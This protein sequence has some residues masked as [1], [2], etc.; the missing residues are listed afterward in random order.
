M[1]V[2]KRRVIFYFILLSSTAWVYLATYYLFTERGSEPDV[3]VNDD[4]L[5]LDNLQ[6]PVDNSKESNPLVLAVYDKTPDRN[7]NKPGEWG[8]GVSLNFLEKKQEEAGYALH[9]FN[10]V[11]SDK[12]SVQR[13]LVDVRN[14][15]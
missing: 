14:A 6:G 4:R 13:N 2:P 3:T 8:Q 10:K 15:K 11:A 5:T 9:A 12:V 7:P 1:I